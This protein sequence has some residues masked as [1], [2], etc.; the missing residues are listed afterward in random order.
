MYC[1]PIVVGGWF[2]LRLAFSLGA[3]WCSCGSSLYSLTRPSNRSCSSWRHN[4]G[5]MKMPASSVHPL[6]HPPPSLSLSLLSPGVASAQPP[7]APHPSQARL[8][9]DPL[10]HAPLVFMVILSFFFP[11]LRLFGSRILRLF[12]YT[13]MR[14]FQ[15]LFLWWR[16]AR[17]APPYLD[18]HSLRLDT[19]RLYHSRISVGQ[20]HK[21]WFLCHFPPPSSRGFLDGFVG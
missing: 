15:R 5:Q 10:G 21:F 20:F 19:A 3:S 1:D 12:T 2:G 6:C 17:C 14:P 11:S 9:L 18:H 16:A 7:L 4:A 13:A 8:A